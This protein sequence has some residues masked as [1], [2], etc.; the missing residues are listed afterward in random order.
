MPLRR[1]RRRDP[2]G[3]LEQLRR[4]VAE[5]E[6]ELDQARLDPGLWVAHRFVYEYGTTVRAGPFKGLELVE[7]AVYS[8]HLADLVTAKLLGCFER[9]LH[10]A[11]ERALDAGYSTFVNVGAAEGYY[12][13]GLARRVPGSRVYAF[14]IEEDRRELCREIAR[15]NG[16]EDR[17]EV[18]G[19][20]RP[21]WLAQLEEDCF[22][23]VDCE[24][25]EVELLGPE[26]AANLRTS[27]LIVELHD[28]IDP[29]S[30]SSIAERFSETHHL[31]YVAATP[32]YSAEY[33]ELSDIF[34]W[35][36][37]ELAISELRAHPMGWAVLTPKSG[38]A[39]HTP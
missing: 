17:V 5:L 4:R 26:Q 22:A 3:E 2:E 19:E 11:I 16:V 23:I 30:T 31:E 12:A 9:E 35:K 13:V 33:P 38:R 27:T 39:A 10:P 29:R 28:F 21:D 24:G 7:R 6:H 20:C 25:C 32:R 8:P 34:G 36:N 15:A 18:L 37:R 1:P 14:E